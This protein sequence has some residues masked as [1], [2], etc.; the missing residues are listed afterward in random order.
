MKKKGEEGEE[1]GSDGEYEETEGEESGGEEGSGSGEEEEKRTPVNAEE[2][3]TRD[4]EGES[5]NKMSER[6]ANE[7]MKEKKQKQMN[8]PAIWSGANPGTPASGRT[9]SPARTRKADEKTPGRKCQNTKAK[10]KKKKRRMVK[11]KSD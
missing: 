5:E 1:D 8:L 4:A 7:A 6:D 9:A 11:R 10:K 2:T 3:V